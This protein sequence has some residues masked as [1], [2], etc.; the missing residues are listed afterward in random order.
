MLPPNLEEAREAATRTVR[1]ASRASDVIA[2]IRA[3]L[4]KEP[5]QMGRL[6][7]KEVIREALAQADSSL[8]SPTFQRST[9]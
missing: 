9:F 6:D 8:S 1:E 5:P 3:R 4:K 7:L 2:R